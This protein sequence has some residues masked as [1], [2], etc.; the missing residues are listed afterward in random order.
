[1]NAE[2]WEA[3]FVLDS[4]EIRY[5]AKGHLPVRDDV[6]FDENAEPNF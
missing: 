5:T 4:D 2:R 6:W 1:M 3:P